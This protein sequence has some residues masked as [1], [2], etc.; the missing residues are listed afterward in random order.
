MKK[1]GVNGLQM[2]DWHMQPGTDN[3]E[4]GPIRIVVDD[5][6]TRCDILDILDL[7]VKSQK[8]PLFVIASV[9]RQSLTC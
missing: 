9:A 6:E 5:R 7:L 8:R 3:S 2:T 1:A 4:Q